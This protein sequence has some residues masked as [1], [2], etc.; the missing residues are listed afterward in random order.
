MSD[1]SENGSNPQFF[2]SPVNF[3]LIS[4]YPKSCFMRKGCD[5]EWKE[6]V[7]GKKEKTLKIAVQ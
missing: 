7:N 2:G 3:G 4:V 6:M 1:G 5:G